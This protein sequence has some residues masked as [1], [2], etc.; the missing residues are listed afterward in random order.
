MCRPTRSTPAVSWPRCCRRRRRSSASRRQSLNAALQQKRSRRAASLSP[1]RTSLRLVAEQAASTSRATASSSSHA[2]SPGSSCRTD[3]SRAA[4][5]HLPAIEAE[6]GDDIEVT[7]PSCGLTG[8]RLPRRAAA[9]ARQAIIDA[10]GSSRTPCA[11]GDRPR[12]VVPAAPES[13]D[14]RPFGGRRLC[15][16]MES[17]RQI[18]AICRSPRC[19]TSPTR[20]AGSSMTSTARDARPPP[21]P[22]RLLATLDAQETAEAVEIVVDLP[23]V[24][25]DDIRIL[26]KGSVVIIA[27]G[28]M[29]PNPGERA[30]PASPG[31]ARFRPLRQAVR[32]TGAFTP[33]ARPPRW[34]TANA[35]AGPEGPRSGA[36]RYRRALRRGPDS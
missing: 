33:R 22:G 20:C 31:R 15:A 4:H 18:D 35:R 14:G 5:R 34:P 29:P 7:P 27:G 12:D 28:K 9:R 10:G 1:G 32:L 16:I 24:A 30:K 17:M 23:G 11:L 8:G 19:A 36:P 26:I 13:P 25:L 6:L 3:Q 21:A 2:A